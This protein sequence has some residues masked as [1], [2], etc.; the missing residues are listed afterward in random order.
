MVE[1]LKND[2]VIIGKIS[3]IRNCLQMIKKATGFKPESLDDQMIEDV[4]VINMQRSIG[5]CIDMA[6]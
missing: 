2:D 6:H 5:A 4:F 1:S 3:I